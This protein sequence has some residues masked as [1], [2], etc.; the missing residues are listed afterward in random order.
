MGKG[1]L[2]GSGRRTTWARAEAASAVESVAARMTALAAEETRLSS[3]IRGPLFDFSSNLVDGAV[4]GERRALLPPDKMAG[5]V[6]GE[7]DAAVGFNEPGDRQ[8]VAT[9]EAADPGAKVV[10]NHP[11]IDV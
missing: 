1:E 4:G 3:C 5:M 10:G 2:L 6:A 9:A 8:T 11:P 7:V